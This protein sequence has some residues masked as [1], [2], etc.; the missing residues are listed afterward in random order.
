MKFLI[1]ADETCI[2]KPIVSIVLKK[3]CLQPLLV[4]LFFI[5]GC[6][7]DKG[8]YTPL[9]EKKTGQKGDGLVL[10]VMPSLPPTKLFT[11]F[12]PLADYLT[13][14]T[15]KIVTVST[16]P[17]FQEYIAR[18]QNGKYELILPNPYQYVM[19]SRTPGYTP[20]AKVSGIP[21]K[22]LIVVRKDS[23]IN[24]ISDLKGKRIAY[25][26]PSALAATMQVRAF[27]KRNG[28]VPERDTKESYAASQ[29]SVIFGVHERLFDA[30][31][32]WPETLERVPDDIMKDLKI[33]VETE[34]LPQR[35]VAVRADIPQETASKVKSSLLGMANDPEG[36]KV[37][38]SMGY[39]GFDDT[40]DREYD[41]V[42][43]WARKNG[44]S[45]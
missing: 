20:L 35:P 22:G 39:K 9:G 42:R 27:L 45:F 37:L 6:S 5:S 29:D 36:Q 40:S 19:V 28:I 34:T 33:L 38:A 11:K 2:M 44:Y 10:G 21:F 12:Q 31:G 17:N 26:D 3:S 24:S 4:L 15:G 30:A 7:G 1:V 13:K 16:A 43:E 25:P 23:G 14:I 18:L 8:T 32:T 41:K